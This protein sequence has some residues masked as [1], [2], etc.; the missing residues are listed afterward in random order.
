MQMA[1]VDH[2]RCPPKLYL[3][4]SIVHGATGMNS[5]VAMASEE[6]ETRSCKSVP[7]LVKFHYPQRARNDREVSRGS[8]SPLLA[9]HAVSPG[10]WL[11]A[12][13]LPRFRSAL[14]SEVTNTPN[15]NGENQRALNRLYLDPVGG[16]R[17]MLGVGQAVRVLIAWGWRN[18]S[19]GRSEESLLVGL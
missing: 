6:S 16:S 3:Q 13:I 15:D 11:E 12:K 18:R 2:K 9:P 1:F 7:G 14:A 10:A 4:L 5:G 19:L 8:W 17:L